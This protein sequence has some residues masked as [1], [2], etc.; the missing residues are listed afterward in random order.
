MISQDCDPRPENGA[1]DH[2]GRMVT[3]VHCAHRLEAIRRLPTH[4]KRPDTILTRARNGNQGRTDAG[5][6]GDPS[7]DRVTPAIEQVHLPGGVQREVEETG[8]RKRRV[9]GRERLETVVDDCSEERSA[10]STRE[11]RKLL[12]SLW[13]V[14]TVQTR[15]IV[16]RP[17][18]GKF[19]APS[20][21]WQ[22]SIKSGRGRPTQTL[23]T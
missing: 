20:M 10:R 1:R 5:S 2:V 19:A 21:G 7:F 22:R 13:P 8:E 9:T 16:A 12:S 4:G 15:L 14:V 11:P 3:V 17:Y 6:D 23:M 18:T